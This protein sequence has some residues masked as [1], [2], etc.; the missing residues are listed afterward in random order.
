MKNK[1][2]ILVACGSG[3]ATSTVAQEK[4]KTILDDEKIPYSI[5]TGTFNEIEGKQSTV[6]LVLVTS[7]F[8]KP[9]EKPVISVFGLISGIGEDKVTENII[10]ECK[11]ILGK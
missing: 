9:I 3:V 2:S 10:E 5:T 6:D 11:K 8:N 4:V 1:V 7:K